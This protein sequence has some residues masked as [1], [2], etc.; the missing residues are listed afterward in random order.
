MMQLS[1][2]QRLT[3][4]T[5]DSKV[6]HHM[7]SSIMRSANMIEHEDMVPATYLKAMRTAQHKEWQKAIN[8]E[9][10]SLIEL[11]T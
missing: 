1:I 2:S 4:P 6:T 11:E 8:T 7:E 9:I 10:R 5:P 3:R